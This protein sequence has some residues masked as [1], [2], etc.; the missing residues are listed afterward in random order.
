MNTE[1]LIGGDVC[2]TERNVAFFAQGDHEAIFNDLLG[3]FS[4]ADACV[5]NLECPIVNNPTP[6]R[7]SGWTLNAPPGTATLLKNSGITAINLANN[8]ILDHGAEG[9]INTIHDLTAVGLPYFG[10]GTNL[11]EASRVLALE[12]GGKRIG[13]LGM[14]EREFCIASETSPGAAPIGAM[15]FMR[16]IRSHEAEY[17]HLIVILHAGK[18]HIP[19]PPP[20]LQQLCRFMIEEGASAVICQHSHHVGWFEEYKK[21]LIVY[22]QGNLVF[23][24]WPGKRKSFYEGYLVKLL[25]G[26]A[27]LAYELIPY[28]QVAPESGT[29]LMPPKEKEAF[30][31]KLKRDSVALQ[32]RELLQR[33]WDDFCYT[34][35]D[36]YINKIRGTNGLLGKLYSKLNLVNRLYNDDDI[37]K[38]Q[39]IIRCE[40]HHEVLESIL[41][42][43]VERR[44]RKR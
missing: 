28:K 41:R 8:H 17:D 35:R 3:V 20:R 12:T 10:A 18:E 1:I 11:Q 29:R 42:R 34:K 5:V 13:F 36:N 31:D 38:L 30:I 40:T 15:G 32:D 7:K 43:E 21:G 23:D 44:C 33:L 22:G 25:L 6:I 2:P 37:L 14:A 19:Y 4:N 16:T 9:A 26:E 27:G 24:R 39:N